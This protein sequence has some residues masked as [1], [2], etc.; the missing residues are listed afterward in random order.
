M[1]NKKLILIKNTPL[2]FS[3]ENDATTLLDAALNSNINLPHGCKSGACGS[4]VANLIKGNI[5]VK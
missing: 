3:V 1:E 5:K 2:K 4:C